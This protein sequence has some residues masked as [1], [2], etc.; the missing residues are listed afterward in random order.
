MR[1]FCATIIHEIALKRELV[2]IKLNWNKKYTTIAM[3]SFVVIAAAI[4]FVVFVFKYESISS[5]FSWVGEVLAPIVIGIIIAYIIN[6]LVQFFDNRV[7]F[8]I[9][10]GQ[11]K[12]K[13]EARNY[14]KRMKKA[15]KRRRSCAKALSVVCAFV[16]V[17]AVVVGIVVAVVPS[18][19]QSVID[20]AARMPDY[21]DSVDAFIDETFAN[22][23]Q[24][25]EML[26]EEFS[27]LED[28]VKMIAEAAE[29]MTL[30]G[31]VSTGVMKLVVTLKNVVIGLVIAIYLLFSKD[32]LIAQMKKIL[33]ALFKN[34]KCQKIV[35][36][37]S[38]SNNIFKTYIVSNLLDS[39]IIFFFMCVGMYA[40]DMPYAMLIAVVCGVT[41][42]I[43]FFGPFIGAIPCGFLILLVD[44]VK[45]IWFGIFV[46]V[47]QQCDG[48]I[49]KPFL[50][51]E[52]MGVPAIW[53]LISIIAGGGL[54]GIAG[55][56]LGVP[57]FTVIYMLFSEFLAGRLKKKNLPTG[58][59]NYYEVSEYVDGYG[60]A[61]EQKPDSAE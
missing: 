42:L 14:E 60:S 46:L 20:L 2:F 39:L 59:D 37:C 43:P 3:Y 16:I 21:V 33:F 36:V 28:I 30:L 6:P 15:V 56:L 17:L 57:V 4:L 5:G 38:K 40:M 26:S 48:N 7:F 52:T 12:L 13:P 8:R 47:L 19:A 58:T 27:G 1:G 61:E 18:L 24:L 55:M 31:Q 44:P 50:F 29:P 49:I 10:D 41:N 25:A 35:S 11:V 51:G 45:V 53:V 22:N 23:P 32:R 9:R 34:G 54:F